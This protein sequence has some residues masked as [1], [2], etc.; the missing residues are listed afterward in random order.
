MH[1]EEQLSVTNLSYEKF[2][3]NEKD[4]QNETASRHEIRFL[5]KNKQA[6]GYGKEREKRFKTKC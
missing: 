1:A 3:W 5:P 4:E 6:Q 2:S